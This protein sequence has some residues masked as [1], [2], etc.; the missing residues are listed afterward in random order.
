MVPF[1]VFDSILPF[2][3]NSHV[4]FLLDLAACR[5]HPGEVRLDI[6]DKHGERLSSVS[7]LRR[8]RVAPSTLQH[9]VCAAEKHLRAADPLA[10]A[11]MLGEPEDSSQPK[12]GSC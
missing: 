6:V 7:Q 3:V 10:I 1:E 8:V 2:T 4:E 5:F 12:N 11:V 9:Y